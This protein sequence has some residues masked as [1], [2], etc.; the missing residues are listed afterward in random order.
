MEKAVLQCNKDQNH[1]P[2]YAQ[3][4]SEHEIKEELSAMGVDIFEPES[5]KEET[6]AQA[7]EEFSSF[8]LHE[9]KDLCKDILRRDTTGSVGE[10]AGGSD[11]FSIYRVQITN[12]DDP[13]YGAANKLLEV[14]HASAGSRYS[15]ILTM[16]KL[17]QY[18]LG[19]CDKRSA[20]RDCRQY[21]ELGNLM[22]ILQFGGPTSGQIRH[23]DAM[24]PNVQICLYMTTDCP[25]TIIYQTEGPM[26]INNGR[27]LLEFWEDCQNHS[28]PSLIKK[29]LG[30]VQESLIGNNAKGAS[31]SKSNRLTC[32]ST[33]LGRNRHTKF[34][35]FWG[36][37]DSQ[38]NCFGK[39]YLPVSQQLSLKVQSG[40][41]LIAG[42]NEIHAGPPTQESRMFAFAI[43]IPK[44]DDTDENDEDKDGE[45]QY[46]PVLLHIDLSCIL[47]SI[48][49]HEY[50][51][52]DPKNEETVKAK[53]FL[54]DI[55]ITLVKDCPTKD[56]LRQIEDDRC[57][58]RDWLEQLLDVIHDDL[59][60]LDLAKHAVESDFIIYSP[61]IVKKRRTKKQ[62][63]KRKDS[64]KKYKSIILFVQPL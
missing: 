16:K 60:V 25:S 20:S 8:V 12:D 39:L 48:M 34:F 24:L 23:I 13:Q 42:G 30:N 47:F 35:S 54:I 43:G 21:V 41:T 15:N 51:L 26:T 40:T 46:S 22:F 14:F 64:R 38:L 17:K 59:K 36:T 58:L 50:A 10:L 9:E 19:M 4:T 62:K 37:I 49:D 33:P 63:Q 7:L 18:M 53:Q 5:R 2:V 28:T 44:E 6:I 29:I 52:T 61:D 56:Y 3:L 32:S 31:K 11:L 57:E 1:I 55:L 45:V 27:Q